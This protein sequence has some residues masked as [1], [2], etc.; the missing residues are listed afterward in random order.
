M[1]DFVVR[2]RFLPALSAEQRA[3]DYVGVA[4]AFGLVWPQDPR[5]VRALLTN[6]GDPDPDAVLASMAPVVAP[7]RL[8]PVVRVWTR[9]VH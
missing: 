1:R 4:D 7:L 6:F 8:H 2:N 5:R 9:A 3:D